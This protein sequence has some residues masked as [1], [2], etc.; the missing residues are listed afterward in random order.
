MKRVIHWFR[1]DLRI[2]DNTALSEAAKRAERV[3]PVFVIEEAF[4]TGPD[5]GAARL[6]FLLQS[7]ESLRKNLSELGYRLIVRS[8]KS[9]EVLPK[10][11]K[12]TS[13]Q[14]VF[15]N[16]RYEPYAQA[17]D[18]RVFNALNAA[19]I[20]F[21]LFK[22]SV[23]WEEQEILTKAGNPFTVYTPYSK[24]WKTK[25]ISAPR[26]KLPA[27][28]CSE[29]TVHSDP[30]PRNSEDLGHAMKQ[31]LT[32]AGERAALERLRQFMAGPIYEYA[33]NRWLAPPDT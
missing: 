12:E 10:L 15:A 5:V 4:R 28:R 23:V 9:E 14:A 32:P 2:S 17:R 31:E 19:G 16:K 6:A 7:L 25:R 29:R 27:V 3:I 18:S 26:S 22:D 8:G 11:C 33:V 21:E 13:A 20:G 30:L 1:R 24:A